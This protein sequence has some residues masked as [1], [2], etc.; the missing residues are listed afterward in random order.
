[1]HPQKVARA[2]L[3]NAEMNRR[4]ARSSENLPKA[5]FLPLV[6]QDS[7]ECSLFT[8]VKKSMDQLSLRPTRLICEIE[9]VK[10][11]DM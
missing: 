5:E 9:A 1:M 10:S 2:L 3:R 6:G 4:H 11:P 8:C 7:N